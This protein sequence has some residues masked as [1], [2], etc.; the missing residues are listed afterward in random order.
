MEPERDG[1]NI[2]K[3]QAMEHS[4]K[5]LN[6]EFRA[7]RQKG[8]FGE[9]CNNHLVLKIL[10]KRIKDR[11]FRVHFIHVVYNYLAETRI[12]NGNVPAENTNSNLFFV[13][14]PFLIEGVLS[15]QYH[16]NNV[17]DG[18]QGVTN[19][20]AVRNSILAANLLKSALLSWADKTG[21]NLGISTCIDTI[22]NLTDIG[23]YLEGRFNTYQ[24]YCSPKIQYLPH[25]KLGPLANEYFQLQKKGF[26]AVLKHLKKGIHPEKHA[27]LHLYLTRISLTSAALF[28]KTTEWI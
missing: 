18:K 27:F 12:E 1:N 8:C 22:F 4:K 2:S 5:W 11:S 21:Q 20:L 9:L 23:Q 13:K 16:H 3:E 19:P 25:N 6:M 7:F 17:F 10:S 15:V 28:V 14:I 24:F 26:D